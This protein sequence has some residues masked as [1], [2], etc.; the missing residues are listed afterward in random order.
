MNEKYPTKLAVFKNIKYENEIIGDE[1][2]KEID[3]YIQQTEYIDVNFTSLDQGDLVALEVAFL[4]KQKT[5]IQSEAQLSVNI[6]ERKIS[7]LSAL[8]WDKGNE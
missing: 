6:I 4:Q 3:G 1:T 2:W 8:T 7:D 5:K